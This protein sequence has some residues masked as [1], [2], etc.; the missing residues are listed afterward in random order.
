MLWMSR[1]TVLLEVMI[2][3]IVIAYCYVCFDVLIINQLQIHWIMEWFFSIQATN[4]LEGKSGIPELEAKFKKT[5]L[6][7]C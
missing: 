3:C 5:Y 2:V 6:V 1:K 4:A 7:I